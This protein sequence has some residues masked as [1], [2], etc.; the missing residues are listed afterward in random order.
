M[1]TIKFENIMVDKII[2][3][4]KENIWEISTWGLK[5]T[6]KFEIEIK[7]PNIISIKYPVEYEFKYDE[8]RKRLEQSIIPLY[9][10]LNRLNYKL[11]CGKTKERESVKTTILSNFLKLK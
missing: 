11:H 9:D 4:L 10:E 5:R 2:K 7:N 6:D 3:S 1:E 8:C